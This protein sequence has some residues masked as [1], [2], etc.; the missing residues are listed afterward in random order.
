MFIKT[1][2]MKEKELFI[3]DFDGVIIFSVFVTF[4]CIIEAAKKVGVKLPGFNLLK[5]C[6]G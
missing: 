1:I 3:F 6:W 2:V 4:E 5:A